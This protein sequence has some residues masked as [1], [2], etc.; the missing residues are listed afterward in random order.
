[1][2]TDTPGYGPGQAWKGLP[3]WECASCPFDSLNETEVIKH[4]AQRHGPTRR[5]RL[6][7]IQA[8]NERGAPIPVTVTEEQQPADAGAEE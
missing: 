5:E 4:V 2:A 3:R 6:A 7:A 1:M 8:Y